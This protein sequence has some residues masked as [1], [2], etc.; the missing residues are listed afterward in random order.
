MTLGSYEVQKLVWSHSLV[1]LENV[2]HF[3]RNLLLFVS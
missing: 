1:S 2:P 3:V